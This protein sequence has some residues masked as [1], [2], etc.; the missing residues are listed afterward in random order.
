MS[1]S[2]EETGALGVEIGEWRFRVLQFEISLR[3]EEDEDE[4]EDEDDER[5]GVLCNLLLFDSFFIFIFNFV[6]GF[7]FLAKSFEWFV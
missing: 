6:V 4:D 2:S 3:R 5:C 7:N 1:E